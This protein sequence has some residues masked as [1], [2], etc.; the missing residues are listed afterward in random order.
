VADSAFDFRQVRTVSD[1]LHAGGPQVELAGGID[2]FF[3]LNRTNEFPSLAAT[4]R[5][6][7]S[8]I[9]MR[10]YTSQPGVQFYIGNYLDQPFQHREGLCLECQTAPDA[11]NNHALPSALLP[12]GQRYRQQI[13]YHFDR[14]G[15]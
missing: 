14:P 6:P 12:A 1:G 11:P 4:V 5:S 10:L 3:L 8:G 2:H 15:D 9:R 13:I 7:D